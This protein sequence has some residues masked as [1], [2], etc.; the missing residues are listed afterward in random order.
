MKC[1]TESGKGKKERRSKFK[2]KNRKRKGKECE[3]EEGK[4]ETKKSNYKIKKRYTSAIKIRRG[5]KNKT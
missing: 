1:R 3:E 2:E 4:E 5:I